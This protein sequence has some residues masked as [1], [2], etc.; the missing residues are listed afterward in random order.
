M[1]D[2]TIFK[3]NNIGTGQAVLL[4]PEA[5]RTH[6]VE[7]K[8][9]W[10]TWGTIMLENLVKTDEESEKISVSGAERESFTYKVRN[11]VK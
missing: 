6:L 2:E 1:T 5:F 9:M 10:A 8:I 4:K 3:A 11:G 7:S